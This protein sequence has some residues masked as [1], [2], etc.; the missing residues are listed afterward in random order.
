MDDAVV[1]APRFPQDL[2]WLNSSKQITL[3]EL[4]GHIVLLDFWTYCCINCIHV[5]PDLK[6]LE[7]K[8]KD[9]PVVVIGVHSAKF[10]NE[11]NSQNIQA[12]IDRYEITHPVVIDENHTMWDAYSVKAWPTFVL[13]DGAGYIRAHGAGEGMRDSLDKAI[14]Q[15]LEEGE[16]ND[17]LVKQ[18]IQISVPEKK[19][20]NQLSFPGKL[21]IDPLHKR[22]YISDS[23]H[24]KI[25]ITELTDATHAK[26]VTTIGSGN[27]GLVDGTYAQAEFNKP[28]GLIHF[29]DILYICD[30]NNHVIRMVDL[31][32]SRV[33]TVAGTG[34]QGF[35]KSGGKSKE[36]ALNSPWDL[37][38]HHRHLYIAMAGSHQIWK[39]D[40]DTGT[41]E[42]YAGTGQENIKDGN[43][44]EALFSQP[45]GI[46]ISN[47]KAYIADSEVSA[48]R[49]LDLSEHT[50]ETLIG[51][52]LFAFGFEDGS[53]EHAKLQ[54]PVGVFASETVLYVADTYN[55]AIRKIDL[56][57]KVVS[58]I[59]G[60]QG[61]NKKVCMIGDKEC[62][63]LPLFEPNDVLE[64]E[65][66]LYIADT[67]NHLIRVFDLEK[68]TLED[69]TIE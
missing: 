57:N 52:G 49:K 39:H 10:A 27:T 51:K 1:R 18:K 4:K 42:L 58:T 15:L 43:R 34:K 55:H 53:F 36:V 29:N 23:N 37:D 67:N 63:L 68:K 8:Y 64:F 30:T 12:A 54:H 46:S 66:K 26:I 59:I 38:M 44:H 31:K 61:N 7:E 47:S 13:I 25:L 60:Y 33:H 5:L 9:K 50:V 2:V 41:I 3:E 17:E 28:Q 40:I 21:A 48:I 69:L 6:F 22:L 11:Q 19:S 45:S 32:N 14:K 62:D 35:E 24:N 65:G 56:T 16:Q 20:T